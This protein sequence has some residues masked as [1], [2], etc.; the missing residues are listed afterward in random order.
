MSF[1]SNITDY[2]S[3]EWAS[4][5]Q[6]TAGKHDKIDPQL[7][8][9]LLEELDQNGYII[10]KNVLPEG[11]VSHIRSEL[12]ELF[13]DHCGRNP[14][15][16]LKT[17]R[18]Y[19]VLNKTHCCDPLVEHPIILELLD[20][21][22]LPNYLLSQLQAIN[23]LSGESPQA[24]HADDGFYLVPRPRQ[25]LGAATIWAIDDFTEENGATIVIP[26]SHKW[27][28]KAPTA[29]EKEQQIPVVMPAGSVV[30]FLG[31]LWHGGGENKS[32]NARLAITAQYCEPWCRQQ[33]NFSLSVP[34]KRVRD[35]SENI[36]RMLGYSIFGPFMGMVNGMHPK[37]LLEIEE[38]QE[39]LR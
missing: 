13:S 14:F 32:P 36:R 33:E 38:D 15:E 25:P 11:T 18:L 5:Y 8:R 12:L 20:R 21:L 17:Q 22:F 3:K 4:K 31:T 10:L 37:R 34:K 35:C 7:I 39:K 26:G 23:I 27:G 1:I 6:S 24:L 9:F 30:F 16:G 19:S 29:K 28:N 2:T